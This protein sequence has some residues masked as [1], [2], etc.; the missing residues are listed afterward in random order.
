MQIG[1][2]SSSLLVRSVHVVA[3]ALAVGGAV[4]TWGLVREATRSRRPTDGVQVVVLAR[5]Y[6]WVFWGAFG[7]LVMTGVGNL[8]SIAPAVPT[9]ET[10]WGTVLLVKLLVILALLALSVPRTLAVCRHGGGAP[11]HAGPDGLDR[12]RQAYGV[13]AVALLAVVVLAMVLAH[14]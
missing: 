1:P 9:P 6:E 5:T 8:G 11:G 3:M 7:L 13:T 14:G 2:L 4:L 10:R 12:L